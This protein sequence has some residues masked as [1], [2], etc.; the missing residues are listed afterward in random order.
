MEGRYHV[1][2]GSQTFKC[3]PALTCLVRSSGEGQQR[4][5]SGE[6]EVIARLRK[7]VLGEREMVVE[8]DKL[9]KHVDFDIN[10][11]FRKEK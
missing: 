10:S 4:M 3:C 9:E 1:S 7:L 8:T 5:N 6:R 2:P 11:V